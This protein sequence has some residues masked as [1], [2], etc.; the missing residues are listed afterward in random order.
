MDKKAN[1]SDSDNDSKQRLFQVLYEKAYIPGEVTLASGKKS[2]FYIDCR[3]VSLLPTGAAL[4]G[5]LFFSLIQTLKRPEIKAVGGVAVGGIPLAVATSISSVNSSQELYS[6]LIRKEKKEHGMGKLIEGIDFLQKGDTV[7]LLEDVV[8]TG[9]S[10]LFGVE[11]IRNAGLLI[12]TVLAIVDRNEGGKETLNQHHI[13]LLSLF[14]K[15]DFLS[16]KS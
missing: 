5:T 6:F 4:L 3:R 13:S 8:T 1:L 16:A 10:V 11:S 7:V 9:A 15:E 12:D 14:Q 2:H